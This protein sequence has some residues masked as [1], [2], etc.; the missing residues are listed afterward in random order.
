MKSKNVEDQAYHAVEMGEIEI[1]NMGR[2][3]RLAVR[4]SNR[5]TRETKQV[6]CNRR[7]AE[8]DNGH[9]L[10]VR[11]MIDGTRF[12][13]LAHRLVWRHFMGRIPAHLTINHKNGNKRDNRL[14]NLELATYSEQRIHAI[15]VLNHSWIQNG[16]KNAMAKLT[17]PQVLEIR[18]LRASGMKLKEIGDI[19]GVSFQAISKIAKHQ[20]WG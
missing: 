17:N 18:K 4:R 8:H 5:W 12:H 16:E 3:W 13:A 9:Y 10:M 7:R 14:E 6:K 2:V 19:F 15:Q 1:D 20:R 11:V